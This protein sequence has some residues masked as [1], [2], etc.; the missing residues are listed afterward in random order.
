[1]EKLQITKD[2]TPECTTFTLVGAFTLESL[3]AVQAAL[4]EDSAP[5]TIIDMS[6]VP[7]LD[8]AGIGAIVNA[9]VSR[10]RN[11]RKLVLVGINE[12]VRQTLEITKVA[13]I[14]NFAGSVQAALA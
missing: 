4:R 10:D 8:S 13:Q 14:L 6:G 3:F 1:M 9:H 11:G 5:R 12:R 7:F 2:S